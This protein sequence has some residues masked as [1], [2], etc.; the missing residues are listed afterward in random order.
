MLI[1]VPDTVCM[2][3]NCCIKLG[4]NPIDANGLAILR[5]PLAASRLLARSPPRLLCVSLVSLASPSLLTLRVDLG[6]LRDERAPPR[7]AVSRPDRKGSSEIFSTGR[8]PDGSPTAPAPAL[9]ERRW[10][11]EAEEILRAESDSEGKGDFA[12]PC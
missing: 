12:E 6:P 4:C 10:R 3:R 7:L 2:R 11:R 9:T 8:L 1:M 5:D